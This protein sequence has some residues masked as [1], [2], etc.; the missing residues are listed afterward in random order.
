M[1][2]KNTIMDTPLLKFEEVPGFFEFAGNIMLTTEE[3]EKPWLTEIPEI[4]RCD[5]D[6]KFSFKWTQDGWVT[7]AV[8][9][10]WVLEVFLEKMGAGEYA[11]PNI[12]KTVAHNNTAGVP[13][14]YVETINVA[15]DDI[16]EGTYR[17]V[18]RIKFM[19]EYP[20]GSGT[21]VNTPIIAFDEVGLVEFYKMP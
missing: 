13:F 21:Y 2:C 14:D 9:G 10:Q 3:V 11:G 15:A 12:I 1:V 8:K 7:Q 5:E 16:A 20:Y 19:M 18:A 6:M 4:C 17:L